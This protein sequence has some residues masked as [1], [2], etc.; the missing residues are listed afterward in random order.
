MPIELALADSYLS[1]RM[2]G[3]IT[4]ADLEAYAQEAEALEAKRAESL[5]RITDL[6][7]VERFDVQFRDM[8]E[9][10]DRRKHR[11][12]TRNVKVASIASQP[13]QVGMA[14]MFQTLSEHPQIEVRIFNSREEALGW[15]GERQA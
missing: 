1:V 12:R 13:V 14:R 7:E 11:P 2:H 6:T 4:A 3:V 5:D 8:F 15:L 10:A 9:L